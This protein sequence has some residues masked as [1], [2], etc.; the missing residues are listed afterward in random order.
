TMSY[1][2][3]HP[4][5]RLFRQIFPVLAMLCSAACG[6][7]DASSRLPGDD[8]PPGG[9]NSSLPQTVLPANPNGTGAALASCGGSA[10][11]V[12]AVPPN[13]MLVVDRSCSMRRLLN[14]DPAVGCFVNNPGD[15]RC[16]G[17]SADDPG[18]RWSVA[19]QA[20]RTLTEDNELRARFGL[21]TFPQPNVGVV[22]GFL[23]SISLGFDFRRAASINT[24][25]TNENPFLTCPPQI[26]ETNTADALQGL[27]EQSAVFAS[28]GRENV[29]LLI[30]DGMA[31]CNGEPRATTLSRVHAQARQ[32]RANN[33]RLGVVA[34][35]VQGA[36]AGQIGQDFFN[37]LNEIA[38]IGDLESPDPG[39][40][41]WSAND[42]AALSSVLDHLVSESLSCS[43][44]VQGTPPD[45]Q[46]LFV[47]LNG[48]ELT[49]SDVDGWT[50]DA[51]TQVVSLHGAP[52]AAFRRNEV[53]QLNVFF[54][55]V[56]QAC[57]AGEESCD[58]LDNDCDGVVDNSCKPSSLI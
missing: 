50:Y 14:P 37:S 10:F 40:K 5:T 6:G 55:C 13:V 16:K 22:C 9:D 17:T 27:N 15:P 19:R 33:V 49:P 36:F 31:F 1:F 2:T 3:L 48:E 43:F 41:F 20:V 47:T 18:M 56:E 7:T 52:C 12:E 35:G 38:E 21:L 44:H 34:F 28:A 54:G 39:Q 29:A 32:L 30:T 51:A 23:P 57:V 8:S 53:S 46:D 25:L 45:G 4:P 58:G 26:G 11:P 24:Q 42:P